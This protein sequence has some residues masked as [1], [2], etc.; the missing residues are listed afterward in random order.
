MPSNRF[1]RKGCFPCAICKKLTRERG[2]GTELCAKCEEISMHEN[3][4][5]DG[6]FPNDDCGEKNCPV[7]NYTTPEQRW[8]K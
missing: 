6:D 1:G 8:W 4:H 5:S 7:R 2:T 3:A